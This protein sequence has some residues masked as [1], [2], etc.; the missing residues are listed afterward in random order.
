MSG[1]EY[2]FGLGL[3]AWVDYPSSPSGRDLNLCLKPSSDSAHTT[4]SGRL[5]HELIARCEKLDL[6]R[7]RA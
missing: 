2:H 3:L 5:F 7:V 4:V 6:M 1:A